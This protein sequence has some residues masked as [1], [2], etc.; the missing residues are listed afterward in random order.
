MRPAAMATA[1]AFG[2]L[3]VGLCVAAPA[4][5]AP[6]ADIVATATT[7]RG[8]DSV[9]LKFVSNFAE[10]FQCLYS[11]NKAAD[12]APPEIIV[13]NTNAVIP[14]NFTTFTPTVGEA[15]F[16]H[17]LP[18]GSYAVYWHCTD[19]FGGDHNNINIGWGPGPTDG[20]LAFTIDTTPTTPPTT[21]PECNGSVCLP[22]LRLGT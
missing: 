9:T 6:D 11:I 21:D 2:A 12:P 3:I 10:T 17:D 14:P 22:P 20:P 16:T 1:A 5:A 19:N 18:D 8:D 15:T 7:V 13:G 4:S